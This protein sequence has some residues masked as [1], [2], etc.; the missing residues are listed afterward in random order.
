VGANPGSDEHSDNIQI[1]SN[2]PNLRITNNWI[3]EQGYYEGKV[4]GNSG[5]TYIHGGTSN[6]LLYENN[7]VAM[8]QGRTEI[9]GLGTGGTSRSNITV[10]NNTWVEGGLAFDNFP[11]FSWEC[12]GGS[13]NTVARNVAVDSDGGFAQNGSA[14]A[15]TWSANLWGRP[16]VVTLDTNGDCTSSNCNPAGQKPIGYRKPSGVD[17]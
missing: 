8:N 9:C 16:S 3:H 12:D 1:V 5:S 4:T 13:G 2:G 15:A 7:L 17:W 6:T 14:G 11:G 10:R